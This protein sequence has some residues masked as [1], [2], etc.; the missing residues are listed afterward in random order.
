MA[1]M[2]FQGDVQ[3]FVTKVQHRGDLV[4]RKVALDLFRSVVLK[5]P[6][7]T[8]RARGN[9][10]VGVNRIP[11]EEGPG[12]DTAP[13]PRIISD[14][15]MAKFGDNVALSNTLPYIGAL[16]YGG[17]PDPPMKGS[18]TAGGYSKQ[19]PEGMVRVSIKEYQPTLNKVVALVK[20]VAP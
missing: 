14:V 10:M 17:F 4:I 9:W 5:T 6:V 16:E 11:T 8:G 2:S 15:S 18:K 19:A 12:I 20:R 1:S 3:S 7:D 13:M